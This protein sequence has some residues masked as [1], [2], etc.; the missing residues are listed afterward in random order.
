MGHPGW[1]FIPTGAVKMPNRDWPPKLRLPKLTAWA[2]L[3]P[4][5]AKKDPSA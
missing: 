3:F 4:A 5:M 1:S 2:W